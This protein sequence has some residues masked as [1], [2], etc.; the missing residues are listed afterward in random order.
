[1]SS[2]AADNPP[3]LAPCIDFLQ[4]LIRTPGLPGEEGAT[5]ELMRAEMEKLGYDEVSVDEVGNVVGR[6]R[7]TDPGSAP[8]V[9]FNTHL[10][11]VDVGDHA[12]WPH[13]PFGGEIHDNHVC[14]RGAVDIKGPL[15][16]QVYGVARILKEASRPAADVLVTAVVQ[17]EIG[18]IGARY[19][20]ENMRPPLVVVGEPSSNSLRRGHRGRSELT[21]RVFGKSVHASVP[22]EGVSPYDVIG[23]FLTRLGELDMPYQEDLGHS[24]VA[25]TLV[26]SDQTS[27]NV[28]PSQID[29]VLDWRHVPGESGEDARAKAQALAEDC[30][31]AGARVEVLLPTY[32][33]VTYTGRTQ[34]LHGNNPAYILPIDH[35]AVAAAC[36]I[37][38]P[39][40]G[41]TAPADVGTWRFATDGGHFAA[42]GCACIGF[43][44]G[45]ELLAHTI[46]ES[47]P[48]S[49]LETALDGNHLLARDLAASV[50]TSMP[51]A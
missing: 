20:M 23:P 5:A 8:E 32:R 49:A 47:I 10:D 41:T 24:S 9:M 33:R 6:I 16:A 44:P 42:A 34:E 29:L 7:G 48:I 38:Q 35:P 1:M 46:K 2:E 50:A 45:D 21:V 30:L 37:L 3:D 18:G 17:E 15:A 39:V 36:T 13:P 25:P 11:H 43:G 27:S 14:G 4:R 51:R 26:S 28:I 12:A 31:V 19:L 40:I 22:E